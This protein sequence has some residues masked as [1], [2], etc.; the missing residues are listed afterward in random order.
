M[1]VKGKTQNLM[2]VVV[3]D[4]H[5]SL[6]GDRA[7]ED[8]ELVQRVYQLNSEKVS[9]TDTGK[10]SVNDIVHSR[11][12]TI[13]QLTIRFVSRFLTHGSIHPTIFL[14]LKSILFKQQ[15]NN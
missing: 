5:E 4:D 15:Y 2:F 1:C 14:N 6:L 12:V 13:H 8:L 7:C 3:P 11:A 10:E 9:D